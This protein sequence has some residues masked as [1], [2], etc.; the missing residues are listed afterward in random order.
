MPKPS[1]GHFCQVC[2]RTVLSREDLGTLEDLVTILF[3]RVG[4]D[5]V[6]M[7]EVGLHKYLLK[8]LEAAKKLPTK[9]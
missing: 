1:T 7:E 3:S 2:Q 8:A 5:D 6:P 4:V 9:E